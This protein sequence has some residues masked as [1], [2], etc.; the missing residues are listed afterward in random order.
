MTRQIRYVAVK[1]LY[2]KFYDG[3][4]LLDDNQEVIVGI[5]FY[6]ALKKKNLGYKP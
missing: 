6:E 2:G 3:L 4:N 1:V 5:D